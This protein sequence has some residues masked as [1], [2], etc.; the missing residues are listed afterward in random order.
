MEEF[1]AWGHV[2]S[3]TVKPQ[4]KYQTVRIKIEIADHMRQAV[5][6]SVWTAYLN[7]TPVRIF[8]AS[9]NLRDRKERSRFQAAA[10]NI[11]ES[12][13]AEALYD[14]MNGSH[15]LLQ[16][17]RAKAFKIIKQNDGTRKLI[18]YLATWEDL[19]RLI[20]RT[21]TWQGNEIHWCRHVTPTLKNLNKNKKVSG[22]KKSVDNGKKHTS[23]GHKERS[24][25]TATGS[26][27]LKV[28][29]P[30]FSS[31]DSKPKSKDKKK[32]PDD[33]KKTETH[34]S[35][36]QKPKISKRQVL[37]KIRDILTRLMDT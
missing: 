18:F 7:T 3:M 28:S 6:V 22:Q 12:L 16:E 30:R 5:N 29:N 2:I 32:T 4:K 23:N 14:V 36:R 26:N 25:R 31:E 15:A 19:E 34:S 13:T 8:P 20:N 33:N 11:P 17:S 21:S 9:W 10:Y 37:E 27:A 1:K 35:R 24:G